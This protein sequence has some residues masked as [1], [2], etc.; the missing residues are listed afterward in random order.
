MHKEVLTVDG[1]VVLVD[2]QDYETVKRYQWVAKPEGSRFYAVTKRPPLTRMHR[3]IMKAKPGQI[4]DHINGNGLDNRRENLRFCTGQQNS[5][6]KKK[7]PF[8]KTGFKGVYWDKLKNK[9][10]A[11]IG[12]QN[13]IKHLGYFDCPFKAARAYDAAAKELHGEFANLNFKQE[14]K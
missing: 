3:M 11:Q 6:N 10:A 2:E 14:S 8:N 9:F 13:K 7:M 1:K 5:C 4:V 12:V